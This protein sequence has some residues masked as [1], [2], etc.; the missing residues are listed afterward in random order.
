M[1]LKDYTCIIYVTGRTNDC[2]CR[3]SFKT[4][5]DL[6]KK[7]YKEFDDSYCVDCKICILDDTYIDVSV[8]KQFGLKSVESRKE[9][10]KIEDYSEFEIILVDIMG[11]AEDI[12]SEKG[13]V[14]L[15]EQLKDKYPTKIIALYTSKSESEAKALCDKYNFDVITKTPG[16]L[17]IEKLKEYVRDLYVP[18]YT[19]LSLEKQLGDQKELT[20]YD[21]AI[22]EDRFVRNVI[23]GEKKYSGIFSELSISQKV[24]I[25]TT[26]ISAVMTLISAFKN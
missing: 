17:V 24:D 10:R 7:Q 2:M 8:F 16:N 1:I 4:K 26:A 15:A 5:K 11:L 21:K 22:I 14:F 9:F 18:Y 12:S 25:I 13:G 6:D 20:F 23:K 3:K 19:L